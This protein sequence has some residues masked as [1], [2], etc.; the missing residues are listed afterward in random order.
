MSN[1][2]VGDVFGPDR[3]F[4]ELRDHR[5]GLTPMTEGWLRASHRDFEM[6]YFLAAISVPHKLVAFGTGSNLQG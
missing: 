3:E 5:A 2:T 4:V 1:K 6:Q